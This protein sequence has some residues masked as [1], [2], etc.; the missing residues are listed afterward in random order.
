MFTISKKFSFSAAHALQGLD[1][2]HPCGRLHGHNYEVELILSSGNLNTEGFVVDYGKLNPFSEHLVEQYDHRHLNAFM[3][4]P[5]VEH[6]CRDLYNWA[7]E[8][9]PQVVA[10]RVS[11]SPRTWCEYREG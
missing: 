11:E 9:W 2:G 5:S 6:L 8:Q 10:V 3:K 4:Q 1:F 7:K